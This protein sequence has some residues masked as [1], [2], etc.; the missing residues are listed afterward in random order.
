MPRDN[1]KENQFFRGWENPAEFLAGEILPPLASWYREAA[2]SLPWRSDPT[3]YHVWISEIM[4]QQ[5]RVEAV[6]PYYERF[7]LELPDVEA[8]AEC[9]EDRLLKLWEGL[10]YYSRAGNLQKAARILAGSYACRLP[11]TKKELLALPGI[12]PYTA[13][14]ILSIAYGKS[15]AAVDG[16]VLRVFARLFGSE[17]DISEPQVKAEADRVLTGAMESLSPVI[18]PGTVTQSLMELG[19]LV[20]VPNGE[21]HCMICPVRERC[22]AQERGLCD[23]LPQKKKK[24]ERKVCEKTVLIIFRDGKLLIRKR[25]AKGLL[26]GLYEFPNFD[27]Y[28]GEEEVRERLRG[29]GLKVLKIREAEN[30]KHIFTHVEWHMKAYV[31]EAEN[32]SASPA[33]IEYSS[34]GRGK[35]S[36]SLLAVTAEEIRDGYSIPGA[37]SAYKRYYM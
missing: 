6:K 29:M 32:T 12:G 26:A 23:S 11:E 13:G 5:T 2:R 27:S 8:L 17:A 31:I 14:A 3:P 28:L 20:C 30:A 37:F 34:G 35:V 16:N 10:G 18:P 15:A 36:G 19:A 25:P 24:A 22:T 1:R 21:P 9:Q 4:L 7:L 33:A